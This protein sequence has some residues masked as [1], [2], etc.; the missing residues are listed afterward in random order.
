MKY[1]TIETH[2]SWIFHSYI[3]MKIQS[4][5]VTFHRAYTSY[6]IR[7]HLP[8]IFHQIIAIETSSSAN[9]K[10]KEQRYSNVYKLYIH[11]CKSHKWCIAAGLIGKRQELWNTLD[12]MRKLCYKV[13]SKTNVKHRWSHTIVNNFSMYKQ[14]IF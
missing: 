2:K 12:K 6:T 9:T 5:I 13:A 14:R 1:V 10:A 11:I 4:A 7:K 8:T 3:G